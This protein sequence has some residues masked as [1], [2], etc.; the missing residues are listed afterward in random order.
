MIDI[1]LLVNI[2]K[3]RTYPLRKLEYSAL[4]TVN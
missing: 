1:N 3:I 2:A 4:L